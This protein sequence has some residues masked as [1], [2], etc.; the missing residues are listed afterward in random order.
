[1]KIKFEITRSSGWMPQYSGSD[2]NWRDHPTLLKLWNWI[3]DCRL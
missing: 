1:M 2:F 3:L